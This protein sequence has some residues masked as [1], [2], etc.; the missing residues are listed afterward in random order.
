MREFAP[1]TGFHLQ[2]LLG[3]IADP[4]TTRAVLP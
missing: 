4:A 1:F 3:F 2:G